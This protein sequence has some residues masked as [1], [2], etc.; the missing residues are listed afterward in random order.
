MTA[1]DLT[2]DRI[3]RSWTHAGGA[4]VAGLAVVGFL[5]AGVPAGATRRGWAVAGRAHGGG[6]GRGLHDA[7]ADSTRRSSRLRWGRWRCCGGL[8]WR[9]SGRSRARWPGLC[10]RPS[11][12]AVTRMLVVP[13]APAAGI[14]KTVGPRLRFSDH[15]H[16]KEL[17][18]CAAFTPPRSLSSPPHCSSLSVSRPQMQPA[19]TRP[20]RSPAAASP[21]PAGRE[22]STPARRRPAKIEGL[23]VR[24]ARAASST[25]TTARRA[26]YWNPA[27]TASGN[28]TVSATFTEPEYM[29]SNDHPHPYGVFIGGNKLETDNATL[30]YCTPYGNGNFIVRGFATGAV[31]AGRAAAARRRT[32]RSRRRKPRGSR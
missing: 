1:I 20:A 11:W 9:S 22:R 4:G 6:A 19:E 18:I 32:R 24:G 2:I 17:E 29:S 15:D 13:P 25:S 3:T 28:Y 12:S 10:W 30:L 7:A 14:F 21:R 8:G 5:S 16:L 23:E 26:I 27:D 31:R